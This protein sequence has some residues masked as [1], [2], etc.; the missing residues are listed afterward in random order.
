MLKCLLNISGI[1]SGFCSVVYIHSEAILYNYNPLPTGFFS[2][3]W[4]EI[5]NITVE[6][7][8]LQQHEKNLLSEHR[9]TLLGSRKGCLHCLQERR[10]WGREITTQ[11]LMYLRGS[12]SRFKNNH[13]VDT[14]GKTL[15]YHN[16]KANPSVIFNKAFKIYVVKLH[17]FVENL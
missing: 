5:P 4:V 10:W 3:F 11:M 1:F 16:S 9:V 7:N 17:L 15:N 6:N 14:A 12:E 2:L 8:V 13:T